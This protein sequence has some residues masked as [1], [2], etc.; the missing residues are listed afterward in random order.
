M[1]ARRRAQF[2]AQAEGDY[3]VTELVQDN[4]TKGKIIAVQISSGDSTTLYERSL[5]PASSDATIHALSDGR[6]VV[7]TELGLVVHTLGDEGVT[8][9]VSVPLDTYELAAFSG[10]L[11]VV[12]TGEK[13]G[14]VTPV[15]IDLGDD[16][17]TEIPPAPGNEQ[18][19]YLNVFARCHVDGRESPGDGRRQFGSPRGI[20]L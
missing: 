15:L 6:V 11:V 5:E 8:R 3:Y 2:G 1:C 10:D 18:P 17:Q 19:H 16:T 9:T 12:L 13:Y 14:D 7:L 4:E 20:A